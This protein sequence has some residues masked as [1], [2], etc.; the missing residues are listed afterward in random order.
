M[1]RRQAHGLC[2][3]AMRVRY[4]HGLCAGPGKVIFAK[5]TQSRGAAILFLPNEPN[6]DRFS[7]V[8]T[9]TAIITKNSAV[10]SFARQSEREYLESCLTQQDRKPGPKGDRAF[11]PLQAALAEG[12]AHGRRSEPSFRR[13]RIPPRGSKG[14]DRCDSLKTTD[15]PRRA[16]GCCRPLQRNGDKA[17]FRSTCDSPHQAQRQLLRCA[18]RGGSPFSIIL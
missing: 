17:A 3:W 18:R 9:A 1:R 16:G 6:F 13:A 2:A 14:H 7:E 8:W 4:A 15:P 12:V 11:A 10:F 5:R